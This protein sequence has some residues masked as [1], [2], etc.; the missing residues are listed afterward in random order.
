MSSLP[1]IVAE[2]IWAGLSVILDSEILIED[3]YS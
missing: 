2:A 3:R 1:D